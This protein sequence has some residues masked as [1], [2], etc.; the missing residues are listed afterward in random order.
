MLSGLE[1][2][3][4]FDALLACFFP[5]A[6]LL[7]GYRLSTPLTWADLYKLLSIRS[8]KSS[9]SHGGFSLETAYQ[10][11]TQYGRL[12]NRENSYRQA[13]YNGLGRSHKRLGN[14]IGYPA[15][16]DKLKAV[17]DLNATITDGIADLASKQ[18]NLRGVSG[19][20]EDLGRVRESL[21]HFI[22]DWSE[23]GA[24][25]RQRIFQPIL[26]VLQRVDHT[27]RMGM[28]VLVPGSGLGRLAWE[29]SQLGMSVVS[30]HA[31]AH[32]SH[33]ARL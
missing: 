5:L 6:I 29:I 32:L 27:K 8:I 1:P 15:K 10:S 31:A 21:K 7:V 14:A 30:L 26:N 3:V 19:G 18:F 13:S 17:T 12:S 24:H 16:L 11:F 28:K 33:S 4:T 25:E 22:R 2:N 9:P 20:G 23:E